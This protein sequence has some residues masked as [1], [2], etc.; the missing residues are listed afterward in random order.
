MAKLKNPSS[1]DEILKET[2]EYASE[3]EKNYYVRIKDPSVEFDNGIFVVNKSTGKVSI[4]YATNY[5]FYIEPNTTKL[6]DPYHQ[7]KLSK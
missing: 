3:D 1:L 5:L 4:E 6:T 2:I 7:M